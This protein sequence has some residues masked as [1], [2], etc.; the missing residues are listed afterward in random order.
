EAIDQTI[1]KEQEKINKLHEIQQ[2]N[3]KL[4]DDQRAQLD[5][6]QAQ[7]Q[8]YGE[9]KTAVQDTKNAQEQV[10]L[11]ID[12][13]TD[14]AGTLNKV[15]GEPVS[16]TVTTDTTEGISNVSVLDRLAELKKTKKINA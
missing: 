13:T 4:S 16:K 6:A 5:S 7:V 15:Y 2:A 10:K 3:G 12:E 1:T 14:A 11:K 9:V 8:K